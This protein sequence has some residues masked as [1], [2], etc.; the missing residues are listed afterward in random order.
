[1][2]VHTTFD[3]VPP[4]P[5]FE[6]KVSLKRDSG[7]VINSGNLLHF[8]NFELEDKPMKKPV[9]AKKR[10]TSM[11]TSELRISVGEQP[12]F[13]TS[14]TSGG[15]VGGGGMF[16][17]LHLSDRGDSD[18]ESDASS[19]YSKHN[20]SRRRFR[21]NP[22]RL[23]RV[24][25][26][27]SQLSSPPLNQPCPP[28]PPPPPPPPPPP[29]RSGGQTSTTLPPPLPLQ[30]GSQLRRVLVY[31]D[32]SGSEFRATSDHQVPAS[33]ASTGPS[34]E[35]GS[36]D[37]GACG[38]NDAKRKRLADQAYEINDD[39]FN[40]GINDK[41]ST[42]RKKRL[43][44][45]KYEFT[46]EDELMLNTNVAPLRRSQTAATAAA[47]A[48]TSMPCPEADLAAVPSCSKSSDNKKSDSPNSGLPPQPS[49]FERVP[50]FSNTAMLSPTHMM[51]S[52]T[53]HASLSGSLSHLPPPTAGQQNSSGKKEGPK[54]AEPQ[55]FYAKFTRRYI[56]LDDEMVSVI[57]GIDVDDDGVDVGYQIGGGYHSALPLEVCF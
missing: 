43:A 24:A 2:T 30:P 12:Y 50:E 19:C 38:S 5:N 56:E 7:V 18:C 47:A 14:S 4:Y 8:L 37:N 28:L 53:H 6:P 45:K 51:M 3:L 55:K 21:M 39:N 22:E 31:T 25:E 57:S 33:V 42:F 46:T 41:L 52:P 27:V 11:Y 34:A 10:P 36:S 48:A 15:A 16:S 9:V 54:C 40:E 13:Q 20:R 26:F 1:M 44:D 32:S 49:H 29:H 35:A 17:P 23:E